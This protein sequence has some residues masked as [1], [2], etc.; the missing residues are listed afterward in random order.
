[1]LPYAPDRNRLESLVGIRSALSKLSK[2]NRELT[3]ERAEE[4]YAAGRRSDAAAIFRALAESGSAPAQL[5]LAQL[6]ER[7]EGVLQNFVE[8]VRWFNAAAEQ[9]SLPAIV[10]LGEIYL[11]GLAAPQIATAAAIERVDRAE[12]TFGQ[13]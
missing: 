5:R 12:P 6:Y 13:A 8:A 1:H 9:G 7:G 2:R 10:R 4:A 3:L 11:T